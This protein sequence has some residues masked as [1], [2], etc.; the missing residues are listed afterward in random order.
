MI[1]N[2]TIKPSVRVCSFNEKWLNFSKNGS[3]SAG[4]TQAEYPLHHNTA[5]CSTLQTSDPLP[6]SWLVRIW[7]DD[8][9]TVVIC[10]CRE[11]QRDVGTYGKNV[12]PRWRCIQ[13]LT[14]DLGDSSM[15]IWQSSHDHMVWQ[16]KR[17]MRRCMHQLPCFRINR[18]RKLA[19]LGA[20]SLAWMTRLPRILG[21]ESIRAY[22]D[23]T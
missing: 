1:C 16:T 21:E 18:V 13:S 14:I 12:C 23:L 3:K 10:I 4:I 17:E 9:Y 19:F 5:F 6:S 7:C 2:N 8:G 15:E 22:R 11:D 20:K